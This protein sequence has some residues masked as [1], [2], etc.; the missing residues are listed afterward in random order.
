LTFSGD[1]FSSLKNIVDCLALSGIECVQSPPDPGGTPAPMLFSG[2]RNIRTGNRT[3]FFFVA[4][5]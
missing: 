2:R 1:F 5:R 3:Y 4:I